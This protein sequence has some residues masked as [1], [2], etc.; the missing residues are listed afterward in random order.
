MAE[1]QNENHTLKSRMKEWRELSDTVNRLEERIAG[2]LNTEKKELKVALVMKERTIRELEAQVDRI[3]ALE[4]RVSGL[5]LWKSQQEKDT[6][7][8]AAELERL[9][10]MIQAQQADA[11]ERT[12]AEAAGLQAEG[13]DRE[14]L[15]AIAQAVK[16]SLQSIKERNKQLVKGFTDSTKNASGL[17]GRLGLDSLYLLLFL[18]FLNKVWDWC[19]WIGWGLYIHVSL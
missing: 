8:R 19:S 13:S 11:S 4:A 3:G 2:T 9:K 14:N 15:H 6:R 12:R 18:W 1:L 17:A 7:E 10:G 16:E 5:L